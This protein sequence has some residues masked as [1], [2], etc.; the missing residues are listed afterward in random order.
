MHV[1]T[2]LL[3]CPLPRNTSPARLYLNSKPLSSWKQMAIFLNQLCREMFPSPNKQ[4]ISSLPLPSYSGPKPMTTSSCCILKPSRARGKC[5]HPVTAISVAK[6]SSGFTWTKIL[7]SS[8]FIADLV[9][10][11]KEKTWHDI[12]KWRVYK[13][14]SGLPVERTQRRYHLPLAHTSFC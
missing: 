13:E 1:F 11:Y 4:V 3:M 14:L 5:W 7:P 6:N 2:E 8:L 10:W 12:K 9:K